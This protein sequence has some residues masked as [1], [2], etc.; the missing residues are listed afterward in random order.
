MYKT[1]E[2]LL[3]ALISKKSN[4]NSLQTQICKLRKKKN[5]DRVMDILYAIEKYNMFH[6][7]EKQWLSHLNLI[8]IQWT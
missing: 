3:E 6:K 1:K 4:I 7:G 2:D 8:V 5:F